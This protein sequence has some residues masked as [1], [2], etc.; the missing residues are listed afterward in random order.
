VQ[1]QVNQF[2]RFLKDNKGYSANTIAA[3]R[4]DLS[5][6]V[7]FLGEAGSNSTDSWAQVDRSLVEAYGTHL[8]KQRYASSTVARKVASVK[9]FFSFLV[10]KRHL[11]ENPATTLDAP[12]VEKRLPLI[13]SEEEVERLLAE[14]AKGRTPKNL[15][16]HALLVL[17]YATGMRVSELITLQMDDVEMSA[18]SVTCVGRDGKPRQL[19]LTQ[20][21]SEVLVE[22]IEKGRA[23]LLRENEESRLFVNQ[24]GRPLTRQGLWLI[25]KSYA[26]A[27]GL[28]PNVTPHTLRHSC[29]AHHLARGADLHKVRDLLGH[30][31]ISTTQIYREVTESAGEGLDPDPS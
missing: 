13:L 23:A 2:L 1:D 7:A 15:R 16:D 28:G 12:K 4:N 24:R 31:N 22:Y 27:A 19:Y 14:P 5:Q 17:L 26:E 25:T 8:E 10:D 6:F 30:A 11:T 21:A 29:A 20:R 9:S 18:A 3:Y